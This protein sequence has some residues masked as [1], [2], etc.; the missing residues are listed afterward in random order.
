MS[1]LPRTRN[2]PEPQGRGGPNASRVGRSA[3]PTP[4]TMPIRAWALNL[5]R[6]RFPVRP[7]VDADKRVPDQ[8]R[9]RSTR[10][11]D[12]H[13]RDEMMLKSDTSSRDS[14]E[15][16]HTYD[17]ARQLRADLQPLARGCLIGPDASFLTRQSCAWMRATNTGPVSCAL[18]AAGVHQPNHLDR[19]SR[20]ASPTPS[21]VQTRRRRSTSPVTFETGGRA[22]FSDLVTRANPCAITRGARIPESSFG[23]TDP[24][25][26]VDG[27]R[28]RTLRASCWSKLRLLRESDRR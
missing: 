25:A 9:T 2:L 15:N 21:A 6:L 3:E 24:L 14:C 13:R 27:R 7:T 23:S 26:T 16:R 20:R 5:R 1:P 18:T 19:L 10:D 8:T 17:R 22:E 12:V 28:P 11:N 4:T